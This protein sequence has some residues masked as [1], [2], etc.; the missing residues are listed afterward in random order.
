MSEKK[1]V[2]IKILEIN[3]ISFSMKSLPESIKDIEFGKNLQYGFGFNFSIDHKNEIF[4][5]RSIVD[6]SVIEIK[7]SVVSLEVDVIFH[8]KNLKE[9]V[10]TNEETKK[11]EVNNDFLATLV[12]VCIGTIRGVLSTKTKGT[13]LAKVPLPIINS[14]E[15]VLQKKN[16]L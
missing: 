13:L 15:F 10:T 11:M 2:S 5:I 6:Y 4:R 3:E 12:G 14:K 9:V 8:V 16:N 7:E 1:T